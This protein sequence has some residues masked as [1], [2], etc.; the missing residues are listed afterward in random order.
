MASSRKQRNAVL[1]DP[2]KTVAYRLQDGASI[3]NF[4]IYR[5]E[6]NNQEL[7]Q[8]DLCGDFITLTSQTNPTHRSS[9]QTQM[10]HSPQSI[11]LRRFLALSS[12][13]LALT[14][15]LTQIM[16]HYGL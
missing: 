12:I 16:S 10:A 2:P 9:K 1:L 3:I 6:D 14:F 7:V 11:L 13:L 5:D 15:I 8:C 4:S